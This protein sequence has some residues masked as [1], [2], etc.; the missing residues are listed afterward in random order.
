MCVPASNLAWRSAIDFS[1]CSMFLPDA[2]AGLAGASKSIVSS[3]S[4]L[5]ALGASNVSKSIA[6]GGTVV[7]A[8]VVSAGGAILLA[9]SSN[10]VFSSSVMPASLRTCSPLGPLIPTAA[11]VI[12]PIAASRAAEPAT[13]SN[14]PTSKPSFCNARLVA[15]CS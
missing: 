15:N 9:A 4:F 1:N 5:G 12:A 6:S 7:A 13:P 2:L 10:A 3:S 14:V 11:P 8:V